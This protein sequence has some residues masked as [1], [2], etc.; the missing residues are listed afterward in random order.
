M[1]QSKNN[2]FYFLLL[3]AIK[4]P[5]MLPITSVLYLRK[6]LKFLSPLHILFKG[7]TKL[8]KNFA[9]YKTIYQTLGKTSNYDI[10]FK[11][12]H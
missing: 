11:I 1:P 4:S 5:F 6:L 9:Y 7:H 3:N 2:P 8:M 10:Y 12:K